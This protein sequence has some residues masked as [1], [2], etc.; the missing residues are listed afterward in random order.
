MSRYKIPFLLLVAFAAGFLLHAWSP[1]AGE[2]SVARQSAPLLELDYDRLRLDVEFEAEAAEFIRK[3]DTNYPA[4]AA[5]SLLAVVML[6]ERYGEPHLFGAQ[7]YSYADR[8]IEAQALLT[9]HILKDSPPEYCEKVAR[10]RSALND[11]NLREIDYSCSTSPGS[12]CARDVRTDYMLAEDA[13]SRW[14]LHFAKHP[15]GVN[16]DPRKAFQK[17]YDRLATDQARLE[18][19]Y[20]DLTREKDP[21]ASLILNEAKKNRPPVVAALDRL[22]EVLKDWPPEVAEDLMPLVLRT[23]QE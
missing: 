10:L 4:T 21:I 14:A 9:K 8:Y 5:E 1:W 13:L 6:H 17:H 11:L 20:E 16:P 23:F 12:G 19:S 22:C 18:K 7:I 15:C 3:L 2:K